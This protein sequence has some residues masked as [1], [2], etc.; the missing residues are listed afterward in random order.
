MDCDNDH[1]DD[2]NDWVTPLEVAMAFPGVEFVVVYS[3]SN[4]KPKN[5]KSLRPRFHVYFPIPL[6]TDAAAYTAIKSALRLS[7][8][9]STRTLSTAQDCF[10]EFRTRRLKY[11]TAICLS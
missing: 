11:T 9:I 3:R 2:A 7:F 10:S 8:R 5:G 4:M 1:S 6:I